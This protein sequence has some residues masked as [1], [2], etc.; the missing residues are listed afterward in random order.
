MSVNI[1]N[2]VDKFIKWVK[3][4]HGE[5]ILNEVKREAGTS[6]DIQTLSEKLNKILLKK[7]FKENETELSGNCD[8]LSF[9]N[10][11]MIL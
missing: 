8:Q 5:K 2:E 9:D 3:E 7:H 10:D 4:V 1:M 6:L 11:F